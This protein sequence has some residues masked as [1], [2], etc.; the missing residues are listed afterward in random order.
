MWAGDQIRYWQGLDY[1]VK[2]VLSSGL[3]GIPFMSYDMSG[4]QYGNNQFKAIDY[5]SEVFLRGTQF[6]AFTVCIQ[7]HGKVRRAYQFEDY[8]L[9]W[10]VPVLGPD[11]EVMKDEDGN[12]V[13][14]TEVIIPK[15]TYGY[16]TD[17]YRAYTKL[18]EHLTPY[19]TSLAREAC[20]TGMP[21]VRHLVLGWQDDAAVHGIEDQFMMGD[22][23]M[24]API[25]A[26]SNGADT[27][28]RS[29]YLPKLEGGAQWLDLNTGV[30]YDGGQTIEVK[31]NLAQLPSFY[32]TGCVEAAPLVEGV[33]ELYAYAN[34]LLP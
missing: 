8:E 32:N 29:V 26:T 27:V 24:I 2:A 16:V 10:E 34:S 19:I 6:T 17:I 20:E 11:G 22:A 28:S 13:T 12:T 30:L 7:T 23:F 1:Q 21:V 18:H 25:L 15:G 9:T 3:S 14:K 33:M 31:A 4:Y 5:E